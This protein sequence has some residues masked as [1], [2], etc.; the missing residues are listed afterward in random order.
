[1]K[2]N[3]II[4]IDAT[5]AQV[6]QAFAK[7]ARIFGTSEYKEWRAYCQDFPGA[8]MVT[9]TIKKAKKNTGVIS[10]KKGFL[11]YWSLPMGDIPRE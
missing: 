6:T 11:W 1:M 8:E 3:A 2:R 5:H 4:T 9:K 10:R 7:Q